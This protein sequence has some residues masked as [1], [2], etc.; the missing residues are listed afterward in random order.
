MIG[1]LLVGGTGVA[2]LYRHESF[3]RSDWKVHI[4]FLEQ[5]LTLLSDIHVSLPLLLA[6]LTIWIA[7]RAVNMPAFADFLVA[8]EAEMNKV[9]WSSRKRLVQD[10]IVVL[11]TVLLLTA[12]LFVVDWFWGTVLS[13]KPIGV[14][15]A[16]KDNA[17]QV[18]TVEGKKVDW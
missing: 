11:A 18:N 9:S 14:L 3:G 13:W 5:D 16:Q 7:W 8:T 1:I 4:P 17:G 12:F 15:P 10:T 2:T 6:G